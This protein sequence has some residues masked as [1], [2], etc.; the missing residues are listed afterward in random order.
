MAASLDERLGHTSDPVRDRC[1]G[2]VL[3]DAPAVPSAWEANL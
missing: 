3:D 2:A 1:R